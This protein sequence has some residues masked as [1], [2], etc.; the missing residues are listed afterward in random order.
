LE[1]EGRPTDAAAVELIDLV[2]VVI[3]KDPVVVPDR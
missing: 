2:R 3:R 1:L